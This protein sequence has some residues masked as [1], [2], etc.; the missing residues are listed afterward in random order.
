MTANVNFFQK[1]RM[2]KFNPIKESDSSKIEEDVEA[3]LAK[4][5]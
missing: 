2:D 3:L 1:F 4:A 5:D